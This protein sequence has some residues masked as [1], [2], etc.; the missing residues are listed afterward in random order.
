MAKKKTSKKHSNA[1]RVGLGLAITTAVAAAAGAYFLYGS[2]D[3]AKNRKA[4]KGWAL[5]AKGEVLEGVEKVKHLDK[6]QYHALVDKVMKK[7]TKLKH[8]SNVEAAALRRELKGHW[9]NIHRSAVSAK[10]KKRTVSKRKT[11]RKKKK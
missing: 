10:P 1:A 7:Y 6:E 11:V 9:N 8:V 5:R 2:K 4:V 3:A